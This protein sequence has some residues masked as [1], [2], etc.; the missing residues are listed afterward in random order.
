MA[1]EVEQDSTCDNDGC[2]VLDAGDEVALTRDDVT[3]PSSVPGH[4]VIEDVPKPVPLRRALQGHGDHVVG[5]ANSVGEPLVAALGIRSCVEHCVHRIGSA[6]PPLLRA[7]HVERLRKGDHPAGGRQ[8]GRCH[9]SLVGDVVE[10]AERVIR[11]PP[12]PIAIRL[13]ARSDLRLGVGSVEFCGV[14]GGNCHCAVSATQ[15]TT[16]VPR[17]AID[18]VMTSPSRKKRLKC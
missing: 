13:G 6:P 12:A 1:P 3:R 18:P 2:R 11:S 5:A 8:S 7:V 17:P 10:S 15:R 9:A 16:C 4:A 14:F